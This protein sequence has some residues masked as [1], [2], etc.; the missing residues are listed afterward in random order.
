MLHQNQ[1]VLLHCKS[2]SAARDHPVLR[3]HHE[4]GSDSEAEKAE[5]LGPQLQHTVLETEQSFRKGRGTLF[6]AAKWPL[7]SIWPGRCK[8]AGLIGV[9]P[10]RSK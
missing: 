2:G 4:L 7:L 5:H 3:P 8:A 9:S 10:G 1:D 6:A